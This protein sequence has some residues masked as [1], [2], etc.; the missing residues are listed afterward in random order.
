LASGAAFSQLAV[1]NAR[2]AVI[3]F[4]EYANSPAVIPFDPDAS[5]ESLSG[6]LSGRISTDVKGPL[7]GGTNIN[8]LL[9]ADT[10][11][12]H[13]YTGTNAV[14]ANI[15]DGHIWNGHETLTHVQQIP[16]NPLALNE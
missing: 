3:G 7:I 4:D 2:G 11:Y 12:S 16:N 15:E 10:F 9:G 13:G 1:T 8:T 6:Y 14:I 5:V